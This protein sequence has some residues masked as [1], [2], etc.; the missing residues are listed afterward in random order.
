M[1][2][3]QTTPTLYGPRERWCP[4]Y[5]GDWPV[6]LDPHSTREGMIPPPCEVCG[7]QL[8]RWLVSNRD[9][10]EARHAR[11]TRMWKLTGSKGPAPVMEQITEH[12]AYDRQCIPAAHASGTRTA[13]EKN[14]HLNPHERV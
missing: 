5:R 3:W 2:T 7:G 1:G 6:Y 12:F 4:A 13:E 8:V 14:L 11:M 10:V 9:G